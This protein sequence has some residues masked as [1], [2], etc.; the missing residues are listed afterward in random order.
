[1]KTSLPGCVSPGSSK[2]RAPWSPWSR[3]YPVPLWIQSSPPSPNTAS[4]P[5]AGVH[6]V[7]PL[8]AERLVVVGA[9]FGEVRP[10]SG[11]DDVVAGTGVDR[12]VPVAALEHVGA[13]EVGDDVVAGAAERPV[14]AAVALEDVVAFVAPEGVVVV[15]GED[16]V[17]D[18]RPVVDGLAVDAGRVD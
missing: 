3:S 8:A 4:A 7:V 15:A 6:E 10:V 17:H 13:V 1:M 9:A 11:E 16:P 12:I 5:L 2:N 18:R 14:V